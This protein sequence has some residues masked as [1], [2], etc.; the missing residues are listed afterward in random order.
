[1]PRF[2]NHD[3]SW[4]LAQG[5]HLIADSPMRLGAAPT[6]HVRWANLLVLVSQVGTTPYPDHRFPGR[7]QPKMNTHKR[8][9]ILCCS[10]WRGRKRNKRFCFSE[11]A[12]PDLSCVLSGSYSKGPSSTIFSLC[13]FLTFSFLSFSVPPSLPF[14]K[15]FIYLFLERGEGRE[16]GRER[17]IKTCVCLLR[18]PH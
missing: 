12:S 18:A 9:S 7:S 1:M 2:H 13:P 5:G 4:W 14:L 8:L 10:C 11:W 17:N 6:H 16:G 15:D 3:T